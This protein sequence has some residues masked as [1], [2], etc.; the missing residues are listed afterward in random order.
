MSFLGDFVHFSL[1]VLQYIQ[2]CKRKRRS[3]V[4]CSPIDE[5]QDWKQWWDEIG[6]I[7]ICTAFCWEFDLGL[8]SISSEF[9]KDF[10]RFLLT[11]RK[12]LALQYRRQ[13]KGHNPSM[14]NFTNALKYFLFCVGC[15]RELANN[16]FAKWS[17]F[18]RSRGVHNKLTVN[19]SF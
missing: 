12:V 8:I 11:L 15:K 3:V 13:I 19:Y 14:T 4:A 2:H 18:K 6:T 16:N 9:R 1:S 5:L 17:I 7:V 10:L